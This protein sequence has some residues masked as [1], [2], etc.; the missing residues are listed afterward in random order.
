MPSLKKLLPS[1]LVLT[2]SACAGG[3]F[4]ETGGI[5]IVR[6]ACP[7][8]AVPAFTGDITLF[9]P[10]SGRDASAIDVVATI[11]NVRTTCNEAGE[12]I[13]ATANFDVLARRSSASGARE[14]VLPYFATVTRAGT[15]IVSKQIGRVA[16]RFEDGQLRTQSSASATASIARAEA[17]LPADVEER[18]NRRRKP[19][20]ADAAIDPMTEPAIRAAVSKASFELLV[21]FQLSNDQ[22]AYNVTR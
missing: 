15:Q 14:V 2:L 20:D 19:G 3:Q 16:L 5:K 17:A 1:L 10:P 4:D 7:A 22:L 9:D 12:Q 11:T 13:V 18:L 6:S 21:G 8:I